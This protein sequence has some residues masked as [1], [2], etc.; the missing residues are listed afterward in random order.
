MHQLEARASK[1]SDP[2]VG[3]EL[4]RVRTALQWC[5][6]GVY[7]RCSVCGVQLPD[8]VPLHDPADMRCTVCRGLHADDDAVH[9]DPPAMPLLSLADG[10][11]RLN[12]SF[13]RMSMLA[14]D[15]CS[16]AD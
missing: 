10:A 16:D 8:R 5:R 2:T 6:A 14:R 3:R 13:V 9:P 7:G 4:A 12:E 11:E 1:A 15:P